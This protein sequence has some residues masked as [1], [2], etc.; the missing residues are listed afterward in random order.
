MK[1][2]SAIQKLIEQ[3]SELPTVGPKTAERYA[4]F[5][6]RQPELWLNDFSNTIAE[7]KK[8]VVH[9]ANCHALTMT[10]P[11]AICAD[12]TRDRSALCVVSETK[13]MLTIEDSHSYAGLYHV[14]GGTLSSINNRGPENLQINSLLMKLRRSGEIKEII[15]ALNPDFE[16]ETTSLYLKRILAE[17]PVRISRLARGLPSGASLDYADQQTIAHALKFRNKYN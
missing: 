8:S 10:S 7:L 5:L 6:L 9:C 14:L 17:F 16:G 4:L 3:L 15:L 13:D 11:C 1:Y 2:P 12:Q